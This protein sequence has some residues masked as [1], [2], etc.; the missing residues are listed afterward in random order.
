MIKN[1]I[2]ENQL[3]TDMSF[4]FL[5][6]LCR[7][8]GCHRI[9]RLHREILCER[10][11]WWRSPSSVK[12]GAGGG[13]RPLWK[14]ELEESV[15]CERWS[16]RSPSSV[17]GGAGGGVRP[18]WKVELE[19]SVLCERWS[20]RSPSS[21]KGG[22]GG[23]RPLW[24]VELVEE[25]VLCERWSWWRSPPTFS[26]GAKCINRSP[27]SGQLAPNAL[28][29]E[30][31]CE[32]NYELHHLSSVPCDEASAGSCEVSVQETEDGPADW[33]FRTVGLIR[34][35]WSFLATPVGREKPKPEANI[36]GLWIRAT[37]GL[38]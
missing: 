29:A 21:V 7:I 1:H 17:K 6:N 4:S 25:S 3:K 13:V 8:Q 38:S 16:W 27:H 2:L 14:V 10:W 32:G 26:F 31:R 5:A 15:L 37:R 30:A 24:K 11:S 36:E 28:H 34:R 9:L 12:G 35:P 20:W 18:L 23:V 33:A 19:E 22:A